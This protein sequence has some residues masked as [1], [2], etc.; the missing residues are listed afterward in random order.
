M[1]EQRPFGRSGHMS[2]VALFG[3]FGKA[4]YDAYRAAWPLPPGHEKRD[5]LYQLYHVINHVNLFG[6]AYLGQAL[7]L[8]KELL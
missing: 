8:M 7:R 2:S 4:C 5:K 1:I 3:G 6:G